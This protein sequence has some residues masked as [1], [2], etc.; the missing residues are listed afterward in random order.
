MAD[1]RINSL[2]TTASSTASD[3]FIAVDG[4]T[5]GTRKLN[6]YS[7]TFGGNAT[8][9]G[10]TN[11]FG[12]GGTGGANSQL[13]LEGGSAAN[14]GGA[15]LYR[16]N[17][18][19][20]A[21]AGMES[22]ILGGGSTSDNYIIY[23]S[24]GLALTVAGQ[25]V[26]ANATTAS[27]TTS[28]GAL[29]V[30]NGTS[31]GLGVGG[32]IT[33][34]GNIVSQGTAILIGNGTDNSA[35]L[36]ATGGPVK[37]FAN[38]TEAGRFATA[39]NLLIGTTTDSSNGKLQLTTHTTSAGGI[40]FGTDTSLYRGAGGNLCLNDTGTNAAF[41]LCNGGTK[42]ADFY[43]QGSTSALIIGPVTA[44]WS[45]VLMSGAGTTALTITSAQQV[46]VNATTASTSTSSGAL[47]VSGG[48]GVAGKVNAG[49]FTTTGHTT[50]AV[51]NVNVS[52]TAV[53]IAIATSVGAIYFVSGYNASGGAQG[54]WLLMVRGTNITT[55]SSD[56]NTGL[57]V[58]FSMS[59]GKLQAATASGTLVT[60]AFA[61]TRS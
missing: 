19:V 60:N 57:T 25:Q 47:V 61:I 24:S 14:G 20:K 18:T 30:G 8:V 51:E 50:S 59:S 23:T 48:A 36:Y 37:F 3:D 35:T 33:A 4:A 49:S 32:Q 13:I 11:T 12:A 38:A 6:A 46:Q 52:T 54:T 44:G 1:I 53:D 45:T 29:V 39:G 15:I 21:Y 55:V 28:T 2:T 7:P 16:K 22:S 26:Q 58:T 17:G 10:N 56:N 43:A 27:T 31:G 9:A 42:R 34:G 41:S 40:G 5:N